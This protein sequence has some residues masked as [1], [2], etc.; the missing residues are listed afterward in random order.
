MPS[1]K[2]SS[3]I[4][5]KVWSHIDQ[6]LNDSDNHSSCDE[7]Q[8]NA[9]QYKEKKNNQHHNVTNL[10]SN[11]KQTQKPQKQQEIHKKDHTQTKTKKEKIKATISPQ[12]AKEHIGGNVSDDG[13]YLYWIGCEN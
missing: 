10:N 2:L 1:N 13:W 5:Y 6:K 9:P 12:K 3:A 4:K 11:I 7:C 8:H